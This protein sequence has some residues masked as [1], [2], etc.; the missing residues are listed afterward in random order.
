MRRS[1]KLAMVA[2]TGLVTVVASAAFAAPILVQEKTNAMA[3]SLQLHDEQ[4]AENMRFTRSSTI[5]VQ[6][7]L[8]EKADAKLEQ[9]RLER[10]ARAN[11]QKMQ[12]Q[13]IRTSKQLSPKQLAQ[14]LSHVGFEGDAHRLAWGIVMRES[15]GRPNAHNDNPAT[16]DDSYGLFQINMY[17]SLGPSRVEKFGLDKESDLFDPMVN[18]KIAH[19]MSAGGKDFGAWGFGP[20]AYKYVSPSSLNRHMDKYPGEVE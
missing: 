9:Q 19:H 7:A 12:L 4:R 20:N 13:E 18:A 11:A 14:L 8:Y 2:T 3:E 10:V 16:G 17:G 15:T 5:E 1:A 6:P